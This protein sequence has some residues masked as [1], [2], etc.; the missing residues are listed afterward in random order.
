MIDRQARINQLVLEIGLPLMEE[1][2]AALRVELSAPCLVEGKWV[3]ILMKLDAGD[4][5]ALL[6]LLNVPEEV[7]P[8]FED[9]FKRLKLKRRK[10]RPPIPSYMPM[11]ENEAAA[12][13]AAWIVRYLTARGAPEDKASEYMSLIYKVPPSKL[14]AVLKGKASGVRNLRKRRAAR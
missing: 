7:R 14:E 13:L 8:H 10:G 3:A 6:P 5:M 12:D 2:L 1:M 11:A 4:L 9:A